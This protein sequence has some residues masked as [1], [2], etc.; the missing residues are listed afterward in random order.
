MKVCDGRLANLSLHQGEAML[1]LAGT[2]P[3]LMDVVY[4]T[5]QNA[6]D[7]KAREIEIKANPGTR[8]LAVRDNG[9]GVSEDR[10]HQALQSVG[11]GVKEISDLGRFGLGLISP[12]GKCKK[13]A[14]TS[15]PEPL[16]TKFLQWHFE[17]EAI[18]KQQE[19]VT[20]PMEQKKL[21][22]A[23]DNLNSGS[24]SHTWWRTEVAIYEYTTD[25][26]LSAWNVD[27]LEYEIRSRYGH[28][29]QKL[30]TTI[31]ITTG[32]GSSKKKKIVKAKGFSGK[33]LPVFNYRD[34]DAGDVRIEM[35]VTSLRNRKRSRKKVNILFGEM[36]NNFRFP[37]SSFA[38]S[39]GGRH[40]LSADVMDA[41]RSNLFEGEI[42]AEN[43]ELRP[44][45]NSFEPNDALI[46]LCAAIEV[47]YK[48]AG[49][50][51]LKAEKAQ[52]QS[53]RYQD[54]GC[55]VLQN[56][57]S[58]F[59]DQEMLD[60][61]KVLFPVGTIG[62]SHVRPKD[63]IL[64]EQ[65]LKSKAPGSDK[66]KQ[67]SGKKRQPSKCEKKGH[68]PVTTTGPEGQKRA[69]VRGNSV[70]LQL[71]FDDFAGSGRVWRLDATNGILSFNITHPDWV[72]CDINDKTITKF[73]E[74]V[75]LQV[76]NMLICKDDYH[77]VIRRYIDQG[78]PALVAWL[79]T[80][81]K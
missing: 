69:L 14:F 6:L 74:I 49:A 76:I 77:E 27:E 62:K 53:V 13:F 60:V 35:H 30:G 42:V 80:R 51:I 63:E 18:R 66:K 4:E 24:G 56:L 41:F 9:I 10:F 29:M 79:T 50:E 39:H 11:K 34:S 40:L 28:V 23:P 5:V 59:R 8:F 22:F 47:W 55:N 26:V 61:V 20:I 68:V 3:T 65:N 54:L 57:V 32:S 75:A 7:V 1:K 38:R 46:G 67:D 81:K 31:T 73:M 58:I 72:A 16:K 2:Y 12:L 70:G 17:T 52:R 64:G 78:I 43:V 48:Q 71:S 44:S 21:R 37:F 45:R 15:C 33:P 19:H 36:D 25:K